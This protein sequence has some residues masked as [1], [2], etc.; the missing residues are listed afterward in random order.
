M[1]TLRLWEASLKSLFA[2]RG[3]R[4]LFA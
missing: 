1:E 3:L 2:Q 4:I